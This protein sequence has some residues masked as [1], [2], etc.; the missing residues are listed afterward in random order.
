MDARFFDDY[1]LFYSTSKTTPYPT[2]LNARHKMLIQSNIE[3]IKDRSVLD[4]ASHDGRWSFAAI[5]A[6]ARSVLG[7]EG[8]H[9]L[10]DNAKANF[11]E[12]GVPAEKFSF[13]V[14]DIHT[15]LRDL[16]PR[17]FDIVFCFGFFYHTPHHFFLLSEIKRLRPRY[18]ILDTA[19]AKTFDSPV[20]EL[21]EENSE[22]EPMAIRDL[23]NENINVIAGAPSKSGLELMLNNLGFNYR[24][25]DWH[26]GEITRW[27]HI[28]DYQRRERVSLVISLS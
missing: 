16:S 14:G 1:P 15:E 27:T 6:G 26:N 13:I 8:R 18:L 22:E 10:V 11:Q 3:I 12:Y 4:I 19:I 23:N 28:E 17:M 21:K 5:K 7:I 25:I 24:Y 2:R 9:Y 20:I